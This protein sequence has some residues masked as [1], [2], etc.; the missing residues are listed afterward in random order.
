MFGIEAARTS[1]LRE[2]YNL[3]HG[4]GNDVNYHHLSVL[5]DLMTNTGKI[6]SID[7]HGINKLDTDPLKR[8]SFEQ[9]MDQLVNAAVFCETDNMNSVSSRIMVGRVIKGGT[10]LCE[11]VLDTKML[12]NSEYTERDST[13]KMF[14]ELTMNP[15]L[16]DLLNKEIDI[17]TPTN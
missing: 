14:N 15:L 12:E 10:G 8:A 2:F 16:T 3:F 17:F 9:M 6:T 1:L 5:V 11:L 4:S 13:V 7:R